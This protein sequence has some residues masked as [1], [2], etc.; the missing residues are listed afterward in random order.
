MTSSSMGVVVY[1]G[2]LWYPIHSKIL[3][4]FGGIVIFISNII[5]LGSTTK[6]C[7]SCEFQGLNSLRPGPEGI[8]GFRVLE[9]SDLGFRGLEFRVWV[10]LGRL[11]KRYIYR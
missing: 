7:Y 2:I 11:P 6:K 5:L 8:L 1:L 3:S 9:V 4:S 10:C